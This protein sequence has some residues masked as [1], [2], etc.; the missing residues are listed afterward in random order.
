MYF[1]PPV[2][3]R[4]H[5]GAFSVRSARTLQFRRSSGAIDGLPSSTDERPAQGADNANGIQ[6]AT[7]ECQAINNGNKV[8]T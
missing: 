7:I 6:N 8:F 3:M 5:F 4:S 2:I 1:T